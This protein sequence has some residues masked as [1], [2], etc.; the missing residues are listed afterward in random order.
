MNDCIFCKIIKQELPCFKVYEDELVLAFLNLYPAT[1]GH[2]L[3]IPKKHYKN[4]F[5]IN[6]NDLKRIIEVAQIISL[7]MKKELQVDGVNLFQ[8]NGEIAE[9][10]IMHFHLH[11]IPRR[12]DDNFRINDCI[13][14][15]K[16][17]DKELEKTLIKIK[18]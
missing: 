13:P 14:S 17:S 10:E 18:I 11:L 4:I 7:K 1:D 2:T 6:N 3:I 9:Q 12:E 16:V 8:S 5:D 15:K